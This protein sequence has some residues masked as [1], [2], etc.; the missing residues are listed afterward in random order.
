MHKDLC[1]ILTSLS[2]SLQIVNIYAQVWLYLLNRCPAEW[3][4]FAFM[5]KHLVTTLK[6]NNRLTAHIELDGCKQGNECMC[7]YSTFTYRYNWILVVIISNFYVPC[8]WRSF[9]IYDLWWH[10]ILSFKVIII[11]INSKQF[12]SYIQFTRLLYHTL[13]LEY[14]STSR[15]H[16]KG[17]FLLMFTWWYSLC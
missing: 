6:P 11:H 17:S 16:V 7:V 2:L 12:Q 15:A 4:E 3:L 1:Y 5:L 8:M 14:D 9:V 10:F 13:I